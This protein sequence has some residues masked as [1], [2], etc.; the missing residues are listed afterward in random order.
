MNIN[1]N[2]KHYWWGDCVW[3]PDEPMV[4]VASNTPWEDPAE[5]DEIPDCPQCGRSLNWNEGA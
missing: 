4:I 2:Q 5:W 3:C 1:I